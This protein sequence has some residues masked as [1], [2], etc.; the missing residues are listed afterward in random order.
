MHRDHAAKLLMRELTE[1]MLIADTCIVQ[2]CV[3]PTEFAKRR[4]D[5]LLRP[6]LFCDI[7]MARESMAA[8]RSDFSYD[9]ACWL[10]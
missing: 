10:R 3:D 2:D 7:G 6:L 8:R 5:D 4:A 1:Q 9:L